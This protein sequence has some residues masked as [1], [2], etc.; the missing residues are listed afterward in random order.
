MPTV[1]SGCNPPA[2][3]RGETTVIDAAAV[4]IAFVASCTCTVKFEVPCA[5]GIPEMTPVV[6]EIERPAGNVPAAMLH[7]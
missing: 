4:A 5:V 2:S 7:A 6:G 1:P 3:V